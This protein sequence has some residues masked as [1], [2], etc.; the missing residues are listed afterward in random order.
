MTKGASTADVKA[1]G[2]LDRAWN[3]AYERN[4]RAQLANILA[5]TSKQ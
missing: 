4:D 2:D 3:E 1:V 5:D